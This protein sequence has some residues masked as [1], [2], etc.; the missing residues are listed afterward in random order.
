VK[1]VRVQRLDIEVDH[2]SAEDFPPCRHPLA[3]QKCVGREA[4]DWDGV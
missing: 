1:P 4:E 3:L 2:G